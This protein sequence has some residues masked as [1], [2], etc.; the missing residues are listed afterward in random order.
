MKLLRSFRF[1]STLALSVFLAH[2]AT[3]ASDDLL[4]AARDAARF[5]DRP[6][7]ERIV[8]ELQDHELAAYA[9]YWLLQID[10]KKESADPAAIKSFLARNEGSYIAERM[11]IDRL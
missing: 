8:P 7:P 11:R 4:L 2:S 9:E 5:G 3:A 10:L 6:R 1:I